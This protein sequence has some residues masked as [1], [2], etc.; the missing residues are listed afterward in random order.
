M[1]HFLLDRSTLKCYFEPKVPYVYDEHC[2]YSSM[3][4][5]IAFNLILSTN[6]RL[7]I[8]LIIIFRLDKGLTTIPQPSKQIFTLPSFRMAENRHQNAKKLKLKHEPL[9][10]SHIVFCSHTLPVP[11]TFY[12]MPVYSF[13]QKYMKMKPF[14]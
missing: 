11:F 13:R 2:L 12:L 4:S 7:Q 3:C 1:I 10:F 8:I 14:N 6:K 5:N 9:V